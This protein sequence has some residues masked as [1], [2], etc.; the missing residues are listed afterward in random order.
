MH[1]VSSAARALRFPILLVALCFLASAVE[2]ATPSQWVK[3]FWP[4]A[5]AAG[6]SRA[7]YDAALRKFHPRPGSPQEGEQPGRV[8]PEDLAL[9][10]QRRFR[11][12]RCHRP[13]AAQS[14]RRPPPQDRSLATASTATLSSR[15]GEWSRPMAK[16]STT[17][18]S[19]RALSVRWRRSPTRAAAAP[20]SGARN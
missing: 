15:S 8:Q 7:T 12:A 16:S 3:S 13:G 20:S 5:K 1:P 4:T 10:S 6:I 14:E 11:E 9:S 19:S 2:A 17:P 18:T